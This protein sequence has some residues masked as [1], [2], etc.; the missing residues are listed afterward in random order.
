MVEFVGAAGDLDI[1]RVPVAALDRP[2][3]RSLRKDRAHSPAGRKLVLDL[4]GVEFVDSAGLAELLSLARV[5]AK[6]G[7]ELKVVAPSPDVRSL[8]TL[9]CLHR[10]VDVY[11]DLGEVLREPSASSVA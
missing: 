8:F 1:Y 10:V 3:L 5:S 9:V 2:A 6:A 11:N 7:G 4:S